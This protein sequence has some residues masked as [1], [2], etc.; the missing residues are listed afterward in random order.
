L[1][2][3]VIFFQRLNYL[4]KQKKTSCK[5]LIIAERTKIMGKRDADGLRV[6]RLYRCLQKRQRAGKKSQLGVG[7]FLFL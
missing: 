4:Q 3:H 2:G 6:S 7:W 5:V 1:D